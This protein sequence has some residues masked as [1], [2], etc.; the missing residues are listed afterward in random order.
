M[1]AAVAEAVAAAKAEAQAAATAAAEAARGEGRA[2]GA[3][4]AAG[5]LL[6]LLYLGNV[7]AQP[8]SLLFCSPLPGLPG[9]Q[10]EGGGRPAQETA[11]VQAPAGSLGKA[12]WVLFFRVRW[13]GALPHP[14]PP[15]PTPCAEL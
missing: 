15:H 3:E 4:E 1:S 12:C 10:Q 14:Q 13:P 6:D 7:R 11:R 9:R 5:T 8:A 2:T